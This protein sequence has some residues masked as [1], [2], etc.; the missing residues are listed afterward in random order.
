MSVEVLYLLRRDEPG[1]TLRE[2]DDVALLIDA[3]TDQGDTIA[4]GT[5][6]TVVAVWGDG[7]NFEVEFA[8]P[9]GSLATVPASGLK[10]LGRQTA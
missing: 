2:L 9:E 3:V 4:A 8:E 10:R 7:A 6:G 1:V 5:D